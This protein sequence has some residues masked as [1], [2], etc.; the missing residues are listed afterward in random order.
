MRRY[1]VSPVVISIRVI[2]SMKGVAPHLIRGRLAARH[3]M[4]RT[5]IRYETREAGFILHNRRRF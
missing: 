4:N 3:P 5:A 2:M 1:P